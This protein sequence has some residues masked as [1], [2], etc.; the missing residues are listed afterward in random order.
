MNTS[1]VIR[2]GTVLATGASVAIAALAVAQ[3]PRAA[4]PAAGG[5]KAKPAAAAAPAASAPNR[6]KDEEAIK[7]LLH[8]FQQQY[9]AA[10]AEALANLFIDDGVLVDSDGV[11]TRGRA[12]ILEQYAAGFEDAA[13]VRIVATLKS[14][15]FLDDNVASLEGT[16]HLTHADQPA[17]SPENTAEPGNTYNVLVVRRDGA[18]KFA[19]VRDY[20][21]PEVVPESNFEHLAEFDWM[22]GDWVDESGE[23][24]ITSSIRWSLNKNFIVRDYTIEIANEKA[25]S[26]VMWLGW[27][28]QS[29]QVKSWVFDSGGGHGEAHWTRIGDNE[30][31]LKARGVSRDGQANS[32]TQVITLVNR[33]VVR[34]S[35]IDRIIAGE[36][37]PEIKEVVM[38]RKAPAAARAATPPA[39][40][41]K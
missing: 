10:N 35:S 1:R 9:A 18:W 30:W 8:D 23:S 32:A 3:Q 20:P 13:G 22:I 19:E 26:G 2:F 4:A 6:A 14:L 40:E 34:Q 21:L 33:D 15:R 38:V 7:A 17:L 41:G 11:S 31:M 36:I 5:A 25:M 28:P 16:F 39:T 12:D 27:D 37:A 29:G 24:K